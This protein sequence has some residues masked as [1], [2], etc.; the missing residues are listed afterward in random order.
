MNFLD[1]ILNFFVPPVIATPPPPKPYFETK[2]VKS[3]NI[4]SGETVWLE[5]PM[6]QIDLRRL[7]DERVHGGDSF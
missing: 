7:K 4:D 1:D 6:S 2:M 3:R 5:M